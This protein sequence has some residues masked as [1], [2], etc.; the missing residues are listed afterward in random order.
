MHV[1]NGILAVSLTIGALVLTV[2]SPARA[3]NPSGETVT[4]VEA[5]YTCMVEKKY[6]DDP[7][8]PVV[9]DEHTYYVC[10]KMCAAQLLEDPASR[11]DV[12]P[13]SGKEVNKATAVVGVSAAGKVYFF[14]NAE[15]LKQFRAPLESVDPEP[16]RTP[17][18]CHPRR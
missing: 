5:K 16:F 1:T 9:I 4:Q 7:Q 11:K 8:E 6:F 12:D 17:R 2:P 18:A 15:N 13:V 10:C 14:E 3:K